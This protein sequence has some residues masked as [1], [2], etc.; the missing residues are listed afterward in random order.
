[1]VTQINLSFG[2]ILIG[3]L[4]FVMAFKGLVVQ[5]KKMHHTPKRK[6]HHAQN[7]QDVSYVKIGLFCLNELGVQVS[8]LGILTYSTI[9]KKL[10]KYQAACVII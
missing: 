1:M 4:R 8:Y 9:N 2:G 6:M 7:S 10:Q 5:E 3:G